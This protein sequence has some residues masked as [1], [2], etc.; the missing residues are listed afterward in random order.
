MMMYELITPLNLVI[1][2]GYLYMLLMFI[3]V[4]IIIGTLQ[5][6]RNNTVYSKINKKGVTSHISIILFCVF[7]SWVFNVFN[8]SEYSKVLIMF[9]MVS[10]G[11]SII[12]NLGK[13]G[14]P[15]PQWLSDKFHVLQDETNKG[16][17]INENKRPRNN[18]QK[19]IR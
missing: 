11:L 9:Y 19:P 13:M 5:A 15:L 18:R 3:I 8:V 14:I 12:E 6:F 16:V 17:K 7:F 4:D 2:D 10:Y 1:H